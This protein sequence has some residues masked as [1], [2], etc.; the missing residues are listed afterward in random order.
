MRNKRVQYDERSWE[1]NILSVIITII[2]VAFV[3]VS[4]IGFAA[5]PFIK[6]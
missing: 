4:L 6:K 3:L 2:F 5:Y 1:D